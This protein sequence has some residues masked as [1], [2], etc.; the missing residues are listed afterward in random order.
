MAE[1]IMIKTPAG[2]LV[3]ANDDEAEKLRRLKAGSTVKVKLSEMRNGKFFRKWWLLAK[4]AFE[5]WSET[6]P[7]ATYKGEPVAHS[8]DRF[9]RDL[10]IMTGRHRC[11]FNALGEMRL[12]ADSISWAK[13]D[14]ETFE[15][16]Y[17]ETINT[18]LGKIL[19]G[20][21][22]DEAS[23]RSQVDYVMSFDW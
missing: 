19:N 22:I 15:R 18:I 2:G 5:I 4:F 17:S 7:R 23:L 3:P 14:E 8:F 11:V 21:D 16:L 9:R 1:V 10:I 6:A 20:Q 13:M 12:E